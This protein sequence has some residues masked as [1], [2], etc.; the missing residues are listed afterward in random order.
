[1]KKSLLIILCCATSLFSLR[2]QETAFNVT[3]STDS[4]LMENYFQCTFTIKNGEAEDFQAPRFEGFEVVSGPNMSSNF[5]MINGDMNRTVSYSYYL[6]PKDTGN[7]FIPPATVKVAD[8]YLETAPVEILVVPN[9]DGIIQ[10]PPAS[11]RRDPF[12]GFDFFGND[13]FFGER[14]QREEPPVRKKKRKTYRL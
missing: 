7:Y 1:M 10:V 3:V 6:R 14:P 5:T 13:D 2:A 8:K 11:D 4:V 9:P 12:Q